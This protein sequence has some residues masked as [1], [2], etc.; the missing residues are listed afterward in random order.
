MKET[1]AILIN[2]TQL[3]N[4]EPPKNTM[5]QYS[6]PYIHEML[7]YFLVLINLRINYNKFA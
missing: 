6:P 7:Q 3:C 2:V 4:V 1:N 5:I